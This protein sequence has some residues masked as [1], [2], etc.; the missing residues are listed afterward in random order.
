MDPKHPYIKLVL[1][2][3][4]ERDHEGDDRAV[5]KFREMHWILSARR[6]VKKIITNY[7]CFTLLN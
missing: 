4:Y 7:Y 6:E 5:L 3:F 2:E 1:K